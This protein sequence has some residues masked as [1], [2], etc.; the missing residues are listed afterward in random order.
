[1]FETATL[2]GG[3][4][5]KRVWT[6]CVGITGEA[7]LVV[8]AM[9]AP[10]VW[11]QVLPKAQLTTWL[12]PPSPL[13]PPPGGRPTV[14]PREA[15]RHTVQFH[16]S[17]LYAYTRMPA[18]PVILN[19]PPD[20][21]ASGP[22]VIGAV[23]GGARDGIPGGLVD[24]LS[25]EAAPPPPHVPVTTAAPKSV[26]R[27]IPRM[28]LGG[29]VLMGRLI[30][31]VEPVYPRIAIQ[32][33]VSG[34]VRLE[35]VVGPDG[36]VRELQVKSGHPLLV[37]AAVEAVSQWVFQPTLLNGDPVEV[38]APVTVTFRLGQ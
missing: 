37:R 20:T 16:D 15:V 30:H 22:G 14:R 29:N 33:R 8:F 1:M 13:P 31:R 32:A 2:A 35:A 21:G 26:D 9:I 12:A 25:R 23:P 3:P 10:M 28:T 24:I 34:E 7:L 38:S 17:Q 18:H 36:R 11:P 6:T 27:P 5:G 19:E 4:P